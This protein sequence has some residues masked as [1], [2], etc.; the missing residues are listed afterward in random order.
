MDTK[1]LED[2]LSLTKTGSFS[3]SSQERNVTQPAFSR[4]IRAL[5]NWLG[6]TL[7]DRRTYPA[8]LTPAGQTFRQ[9]AEIIL[10]ELNQSRALFRETLLNRRSDLHIAAASTL[11]FHFIPHWLRSLEAE[12]GRLTTH[13]FTRNFHDMVDQ[14]VQGEID[15]VLQY[16]HADVPILYETRQ[17]DQFTLAS[18]PMVLVSAVDPKN[19]QALYDPSRGDGVS[20]P[21][22]GY[23]SDGYFA[24]VEKLVFE[25]NAAAKVSFTRLNES[26]TSEVLKY[27]AIESGA[28]ALVPESCARSEI[29]QGQLRVVG[30][31]AWSTPLSVH[32][33]RAH[34][35]TRPLVAKVWDALSQTGQI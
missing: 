11:N 17:F 7:F 2:F 20:I 10:D 24:E 22:M 5:E 34:S 15:L 29:S 31:D 25:Q 26:P 19:G 6:V 12:N 13:V 33:Y 35:G 3:R 18:D 4:R 14:L 30:G 8:S 32:I 9:S 28:L 23:S 1:W 16:A 21:Y 27:M